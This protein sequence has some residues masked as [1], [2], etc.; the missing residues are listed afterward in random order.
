MTTYGSLGI[1]VMQT[2][3]G[4]S[5]GAGD[6]SIMKNRIINGAMVSDQRNNGGSFSV[7]TLSYFAGYSYTVDRWNAFCSVVSKF[8]VQ[9]NAGSVTSPVGFSNYLGCT[10][11]SAYSIAAGDYFGI[12]QRI[13]GFNT[14]DLGWGTANAKTVTLSFEVYSSLTGN[15]GGAFTN[16]A[17]NRSY[18]FTYSIPVANTWTPISITVPGDTTGA[19]AA[20]TGTGIQLTFGL[21]VGST[22]SGAAGSWSSN[23]YMSSTGATSVVGTNGATFYITGVQLEVGSFATGFEYRQYQQ[24][25]ALCQ[26]YYQMTTDVWSNYN[27]MFGATIGAN[28]GLKACIFPVTM[29]ASPTV[30]SYSESGTA[31][32]FSINRGG[33]Y[34]AGYLSIPSGFTLTNGTGGNITVTELT[35]K[36]TASA[37][38]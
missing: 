34:S 37:E 7:S 36:W 15:F 18:P 9:Q 38:L 27:Y 2:S 25:L 31:N 13:E 22:Y 12:G 1:D 26:R 33:A 23:L 3:S 6:A 17:G 5:L 29:R 19:W 35:F 10:S 24:E 11:S 20:T 30:V 28:Y 16:S 14:S 4:A 21:G 8:T 32:A